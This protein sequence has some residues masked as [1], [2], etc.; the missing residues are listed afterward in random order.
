[1][2]KITATLGFIF[3]NDLQEVLLIR[4]R[5]PEWQA[6]KIIFCC[7]GAESVYADEELLVLPA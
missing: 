6:E 1:M 3:S 2:K 7:D 4:K 5:H